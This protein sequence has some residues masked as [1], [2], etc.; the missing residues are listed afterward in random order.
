MKY[1]STIIRNVGGYCPKEETGDR[2]SD[3][4]PLWIV[5]F[6]DDG[7]THRL[8]SETFQTRAAAVARAGRVN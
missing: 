4:P 7:G 5:E 6:Y 3:L 8:T 2:T 1:P